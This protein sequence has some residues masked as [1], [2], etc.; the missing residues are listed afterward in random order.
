MKVPYLDLQAQYQS[1]KPEIDA[2][3]QR[4]LDSSAYV[5]GPAVGQFEKDFARY[6]SVESCAGVNSGTSALHLALLALDVGPGD[7]VITAA[8]TFVAT[9][10]AIAYTGAKPV[11]V[12]V[13]PES[14]NLDPK[15][16]SMAL[17]QKTKAII[18]VH[19]YGRMADM[20]PILQIA[21]K[22]H[23]AVLEDAAQAHGAE[24][25]GHRAG[26]LG[27]IAGFSFYPGKNLGAYGEGG[28]VCTSDATLDKAVRMLRDH[29]SERKYYHD[30]LG[31]NARMEGIQ[32]AVLG[33]KLKYL[34]RWNE[35]RRTIAAQY[36]DLLA[37]LPIALPHMD[38]DFL[39]VFHLYVIE[40]DRRDELQKYLGTRE[41]PSLIHYPV[42]AHLQQGFEFLGYKKGE[43]PITE[44]LCREV[45]SLPIFPEMTPDQVAYVAAAIRDFFNGR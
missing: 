4:V 6:C 40:S 16:L 42:P 37:G 38:D 39:Q 34:D 30:R 45:L 21:E 8:N 5:L 19:L 35:A 2:A 11:L 13:E 15:L 27:R 29:G 17:S 9:I 10:A 14:R 44:R 32:G 41:I 31:F 1:I 20:D 22:Y 36:N 18:P 24:Y 26:S 7:E 43:F 3:L 23:I 12:D 25:K 33:V 28:A